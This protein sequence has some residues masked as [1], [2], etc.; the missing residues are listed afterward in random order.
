MSTPSSS[1]ASSD[2]LNPFLLLSYLVDT[3]NPLDILSTTA[4][5]RPA[6]PRSMHSTGSSA[7]EKAGLVTSV[8][9]DKTGTLTKGF[10]ALIAR[11]CTSPVPI[12]TPLHL[13]AHISQHHQWL[14][15]DISL[16]LLG[17]VHCRCCDLWCIRLVVPIDHENERTPTDDD[18]DDD[19]VDVERLGVDPMELAA[20]LEQRSAHP[21]AS[22][23]VSG[24][25]FARSQDISRQ[26]NLHRLFFQRTVVA[27]QKAMSSFRI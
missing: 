26:Y 20:A 1:I 24:E 6:M 4:T 11:C 9:V 8:A 25:P 12:P 13:L 10:F 7:I 16:S 17:F 19:V 18:D 15:C 27:S 21:L 22:A 3:H 2:P 23:I 14:E 5:P